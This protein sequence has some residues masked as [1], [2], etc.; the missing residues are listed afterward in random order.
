MFKFGMDLHLSKGQIWST[1]KYV[2]VY[3]WM[4]TNCD[5]AATG[6]DFNLF[7]K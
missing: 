2:P 5:K 7:R 4:L 1:L 3:F 6:L